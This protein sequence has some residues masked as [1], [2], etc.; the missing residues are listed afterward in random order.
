M[1]IWWLI[2]ILGLLILYEWIRR[3]YTIFWFFGTH[4]LTKKAP[5]LPSLPNWPFVSIIVPARNE[6]RGI[7]QTLNSLLNLDYPS[8]E[9]I[10]VD[11]R[12]EDKTGTIMDHLAKQDKRLTVIHN[13]EIPGDWLGKQY[14]IH[15][16]VQVAKGDYILLTD[17][18]VIFNNETLK[19]A[20]KYVSH[21][22]LD[23]LVLLTSHIP[24]GFWENALWTFFVSLFMVH[25]NPKAVSNP[26]KK[27]SIGLGQFNLV[28][29][30]AY[31][32]AGGDEAIRLRIPQDMNLG[33]LLKFRSQTGY[34]LWKRLNKAKM[35]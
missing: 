11:D 35:V 4:R 17:G 2:C 24:G 5:K 21:R 9:V 26:S 29:R 3:A 27:D 20:M 13:N 34:T 18:D 6:E 7:E 15:K 30:V 31:D 16:A 25:R 10:A 22:Q 19:L 33:R 23:H 12:S 1:I 28:K 32:N 14:V 8:F